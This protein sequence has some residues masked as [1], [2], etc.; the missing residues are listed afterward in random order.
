M[1][2]AYNHSYEKRIGKQLA[3]GLPVTEIVRLQS[4]IGEFLSLY[5]GYGTEKPRGAVIILHGMGGH[6]D[7]PEIV[8][9][10]RTTLPAS[11]WATLSVQ[12]PVLSPAD[13]IADYGL[14]MGEATQRIEAA[15]Q[16]LQDWRFLNIVV[17]GYSFGAATA[18]QALSTDN[19]NKNVNAFVGISMQAPQFL[20]PRLKLLKQLQSI[21]IPV[22]DIYGSRDTIEVL[23]EADDRRLAARK[24]GNAAYRQIIVEGA[25]HYFT[26]LEDVLIK[27]IQGWLV[28]A[29][30]GLK[31]MAE[32]AN[33]NKQEAKQE[34]KPGE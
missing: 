30:S 1:T 7:W 23:N 32:D 26:G 9:P 24:N 22:L 29:T 19:I 6:P 13:S 28:K 4:A 3:E 25:D 2:L 5:R 17:I 21:S 12:L 16:Q 27:R 31:I 10:L 20:S 8:N 15:V 18:A 14:T 11:G 34:A 33:I